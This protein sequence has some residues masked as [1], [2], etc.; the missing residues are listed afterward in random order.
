MTMECSRTR[1][2]LEDIA[3]G[4]VAV[5][6]IETH[7]AACSAC[8]TTLAVLRERAKKL[9]ERLQRLASVGVPDGLRDRVVSRLSADAGRRAAWP[10]MWI[11]GVTSALAVATSVMIG[12]F[13]AQQYAQ[14]SASDRS[15]DHAVVSAAADI[16]EWRSPTDML[17]ARQADEQ[18]PIRPE[19]QRGNRQ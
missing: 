16:S 12:L 7:V 3:L 9:D 10:S 19:G 17:L 15:Y 14:R 6:E 13:F 1:E 2:R 4:A 8:A 5:P 11:I 18:N